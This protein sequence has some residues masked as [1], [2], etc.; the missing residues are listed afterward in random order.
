[1][2]NTFRFICV[3]FGESVFGI[4][5]RMC[6][7]VHIFVSLSIIY[8]FVWLF[9]LLFIILF[10]TSIYICVCVRV[11]VYVSTVCACIYRVCVCLRVSIKQGSISS[12]CVFLFTTN[13]SEAPSTCVKM[14]G[15]VAQ[16]C[17]ASSLVSDEKTTSAR[18][19][20]ARIKVASWTEI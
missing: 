18:C 5:K 9:V 14:A 1:M 12:M 2:Q 11:C 19:A 16:P 3:F 20:M 8:L 10:I 17:S 13:R 15:S 7:R 6:N 4:L